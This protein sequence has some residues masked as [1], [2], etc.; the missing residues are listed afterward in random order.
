MVLKGGKTPVLSKSNS[1]SKSNLSGT[2]HTSTHSD[3][4]NNKKKK[5]FLGLF[6]KQKSTDKSKEFISM[7]P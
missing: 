2:Q 1:N 6:N 7:A 3:Q 5:G 4:D